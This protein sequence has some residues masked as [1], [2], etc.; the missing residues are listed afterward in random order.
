MFL[1]LKSVVTAAILQFPYYHPEWPA[2]LNFGGLGFTIGHEMTHGFD[3][4]G[5]LKIF[6]ILFLWLN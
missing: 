1:Y 2:P 4:D 3:S 6:L 5:D